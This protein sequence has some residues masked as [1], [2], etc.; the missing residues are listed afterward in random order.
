MDMPEDKVDEMNEIKHVLTRECR[1]EMEIVCKK[2]ITS[3][4]IKMMPVGVLLFYVL[5]GCEFATPGIH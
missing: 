1:T 4:E 5:L 3:I 2:Q